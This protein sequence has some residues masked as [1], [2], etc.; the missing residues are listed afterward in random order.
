MSERKSRWRVY[1]EA[2]PKYDI[3]LDQNWFKGRDAAFQSVGCPI[4]QPLSHEFVR[5]WAVDLMIN[6]HDP[7]V[8]EERLTD[9][10]VWRCL[11]NWQ[12]EIHGE[13]DA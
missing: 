12:H 4:P 7:V 11:D 2:T 5:Q 8:Y 10:D 9:N 13:W 1:Y 6:N 3:V